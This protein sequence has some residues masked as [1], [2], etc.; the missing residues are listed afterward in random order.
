MNRKLTF[1]VL[2]TVSILV[3]S[4]GITTAAEPPQENQKLKSMISELEQKIEDADKRMIAHPSFLEELKELVGK[5]KAQLRDLFFRE[6]FTDGNYTKS[7]KWTVKSGQFSVN[8]KGYLVNSVVPK[9][10][11]SQAEPSQEQKPSIEAEA[12]GILLDSIF[13][14]PEKKEPAPPKP[15]SQ[16]EPVQPASIYTQKKFPPAFEMT[17]RF[18]SSKIGAFDITL[19]GAPKLSPRY[20]LKIMANHS[21]QNPIEIVRE[22]TGR[23]FT[24]GAADKFPKINDNKF[25]TL[26]WIRYS[27]GAMNVLIDN[28]IVLQTYEVYYRDD[29]TGFEITNNGGSHSWDSVLIYKSLQPKV[30]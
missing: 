2:L 4:Y 10:D 20:R 12:V 25:H 27:N 16:P 17:M 7:P 28:T 1:G 21:S 6:T 5:Y 8:K 22:T 14:S 23:A 18:K 30:N 15:K 11:P 3:F 26:S 19:L 9:T 13:G 24:V 29:F